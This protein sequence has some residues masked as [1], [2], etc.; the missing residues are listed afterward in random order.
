[1]MI[2]TFGLILFFSLSQSKNQFMPNLP[3]GEYRLVINKVYPCEST[4][5]HPLK[6]NWY[7]SKKTSSIT[8]LK[9]NITSSIPFDD[10][11]TL[12]VN[13]ASWG[14]TGGWIPNSN[15]IITKKACSNIK[16]LAGNTWFTLI[17]GFKIPS[18][19]CPIPV[20]TYITSGIDMK[21]IEDT[22]FNKVYFYGKYKL[23]IRYKNFKNEVVGCVVVEIN[24][25][26]PWETQI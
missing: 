10:T 6:F 17:K 25:I 24:L 16:M 7:L 20:G 1:M 15:M 13:F 23:M 26:R 5:N 11:L 8:E 21:K 9:G 12:D 18:D 22:N 14:S 2:K 4:K 3:L 19:S